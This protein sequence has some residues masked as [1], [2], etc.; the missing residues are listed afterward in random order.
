MDFHY[1]RIDGSKTNIYKA[2]GLLYGI[3]QQQLTKIIE[4]N[5]FDDLQFFNTGIASTQRNFW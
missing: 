4:K 5:K 3:K 1:R 2:K